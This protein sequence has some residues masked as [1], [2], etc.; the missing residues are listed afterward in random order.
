MEKE[1]SVPLLFTLTEL[2]GRRSKDER[3]MIV[4]GIEVPRRY[5]IIFI[6]SF[7]PALF[8]GLFVWPFLGSTAAFTAMI[9]FI[10]VVFIALEARSRKGLKLRMYQ[11][12][13]DKGRSHLRRLNGHVIRCGQPV[14]RISA[15]PGYIRF[16]AVDARDLDP[17]QMP[18]SAAE[19][20]FLGD[21]FEPIER[22]AKT[23][24]RP[25]VIRVTD[26]IDD[27]IMDEAGL[28]YDE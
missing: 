1:Q 9:V 11:T 21:E 24:P 3:T 16:S 2:T 19:D 15:T 27:G 25:D 5:G 13:F 10:A 12:V 23:N 17:V 28:V 18:A 7:L 22:I 6:A 8:L 20:V 4:Q 14:D 26:S